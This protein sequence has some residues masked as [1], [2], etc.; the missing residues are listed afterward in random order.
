MRPNSP[1][2]S[3]VQ[4]IFEKHESIGEK[5]FPNAF[6]PFCGIPPLM[7]FKEQPH[8]SDSDLWGCSSSILSS[9][10]LTTSLI[11]TSN[12]EQMR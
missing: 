3:I 6:M 1:H 11:F 5:N 8:T 4:R 7:K 10:S 2:E 9:I 12:A